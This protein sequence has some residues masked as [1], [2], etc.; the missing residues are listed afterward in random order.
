MKHL[1]LQYSS[2]GIITDR[3]GQILLVKHATHKPY[4][5]PGGH[6]E[7]NETFQ[8]AFI[9][10]A[11]E[12]LDIAV[13]LIGMVTIYKENNI[14]SLPAPARVQTIEYENERGP[15]RKYEEFFLAHMVSG[16]ITVQASEI[17]SF[18]WFTLEQIRNMSDT[19][20]YP[21]IRELVIGVSV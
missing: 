5:L 1:P 18:G 11:R 13:E 2:R 17:A 8:E 20:I 4:T 9:R 7:K 12:E 19:E 10:E 16:T 3:D 14:Q 21:S 15:Q 6:L